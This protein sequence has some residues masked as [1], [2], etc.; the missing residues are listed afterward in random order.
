MR[1]ILERDFIIK[2][3]CATCSQDGK[4]DYQSLYPVPDCATVDSVEHYL[5]NLHSSE[6]D[7]TATRGMIE[8]ARAAGVKEGREKVLDEFA[9]WYH[10]P[11]CPPGKD[12]EKCTFHGDCLSCIIDSLRQQ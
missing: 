12:S 3:I 5:E 9:M 2:N 7:T 10:S 8:A 11:D 4:C 6:K 1:I